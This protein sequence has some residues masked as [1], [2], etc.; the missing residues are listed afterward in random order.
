MVWDVDQIIPV[1]TSLVLPFT[2]TSRLLAIDITAANF[3]PTW[4]RSGFLRSFLTF[5]GQEFVGNNFQTR[6]GNQL[7]EIP[8]QNYQLEFTPQSW[9]SDT[10]IKIK[11]LSITETELIMGINY[12]SSAPVTASSATTSSVTAI[13]TSGIIMP[14]NPARLL[15]GTI[16]NNSNK[17]LWIRFDTTAATTAFPCVAVPPGGNVDIEDGY[18]GQVTGI[19]EAAATGTATVLQYI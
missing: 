8:F 12:A 15:G 13:A 17:N 3:R 7:F 2:F 5:D 11:Q 19:W 9:M 10:N 16:V 6:F 4:Y 1:N 18:V 14:A